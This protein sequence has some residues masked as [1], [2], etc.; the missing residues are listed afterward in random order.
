MNILLASPHRP[1]ALWTKC[2][3]QFAPLFP[4]EAAEV[5]SYGIPAFKDKRVLVWFATFSNHCSLF[6]TASVIGAFKDELKAYTISKGTIQFPLDQP[7]PVALI[8][9]L[10]KARVAQ[11]E[12]KKR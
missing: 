2:A 3:W 1:A 8:R 5:I 9:K 6:P 12:G 11:N 4:P 10:V 7:L